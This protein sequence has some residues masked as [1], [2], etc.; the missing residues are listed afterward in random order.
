[1]YKIKA[2]KQFTTTL[3][4]LT[5][6]LFKGNHETPQR[7]F[8]KKKRKHAHTHTER[9]K[10]RR[11]RQKTKTSF[12]LMVTKIFLEKPARLRGT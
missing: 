2:T 8:K 5:K 3:K 10:R 1:M 6:K 7:H 9:N 4:H 11:D 12:F